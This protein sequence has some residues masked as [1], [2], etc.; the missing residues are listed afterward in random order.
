MLSRGVRVNKE[1][2]YMVSATKLG[3]AADKNESGLKTSGPRVK[4]EA[5]LHEFRKNTPNSTK[6]KSQS[7]APGAEKA[8]KRN[9]NTV[10]SVTNLYFSKKH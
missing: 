3:P 2:K 6:S 5:R 8:L 7:S 9:E 4:S 10:K 1:Y